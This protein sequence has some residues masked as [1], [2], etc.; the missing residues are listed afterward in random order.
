MYGPNKA[1]ADALRSFKGGR[2]AAANDTDD[3]EGYYPALNDIRLPMANPPPPR[4]HKL[5]PISRFYSQ[6]QIS[7]RIVD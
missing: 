4:D 1:W 5:K 6:Y 7:K 2:L 3:E